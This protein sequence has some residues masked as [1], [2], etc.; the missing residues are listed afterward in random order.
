M[1]PYN[2]N[3]RRIGHYR[4]V[5]LMEFISGFID[6][7][8][9]LFNVHYIANYLHTG[10]Y[11]DILCTVVIG[12]HACSTIA[13]ISVLTGLVISQLPVLCMMI[14]TVAIACS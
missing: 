8:F 3:N 5:N 12:S 9:H 6:A 10:H 11:I 2:L 13:N 7:N 1:Q 4:A 14:T